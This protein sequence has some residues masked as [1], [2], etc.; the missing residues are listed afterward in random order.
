[1]EFVRGWVSLRNKGE[2]ARFKLN[3][4]LSSYKAIKGIQLA[5]ID[6]VP[7]KENSFIR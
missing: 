1:M 2:E 3:I 4:P 7:L 5:A 6:G